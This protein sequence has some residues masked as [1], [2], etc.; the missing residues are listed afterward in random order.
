MMCGCR[1]SDHI[2]SGIGIG[3]LQVLQTLMRGCKAVQERMT[4]LFFRPCCKVG[5]IKER[6]NE[7]LSQSDLA[8]CAQSH[9]FAA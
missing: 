4:L 6:V 9:G 2:A 3:E 8:L 7:T 1:A 5:A